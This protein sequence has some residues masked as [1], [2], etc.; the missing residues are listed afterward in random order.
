MST[1]VL[2]LANIHIVR[3]G[4]DVLAEQ[5]KTLIKSGL[6]FFAIISV[7][8]IYL[9]G[10]VVADTAMLNKMQ[11]SQKQEMQRLGETESRALSQNQNLTVPYF[12]GQGYEEPKNLDVIRR[13]QNVA[14]NSLSSFD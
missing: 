4:S 1:L 14:K 9:V 6:I 10:S 13:K 3:H 2:K 12:L 11:I 8:Y 5:K 7:L